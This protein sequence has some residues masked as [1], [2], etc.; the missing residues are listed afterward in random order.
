MANESEIDDAAAVM[1]PINRAWLG[2]NVGDLAPMESIRGL[3][4]SFP[5]LAEEFRG[6]NGFLL[7][8][9]ILPKRNYSRIQQA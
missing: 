5:V 1:R 8:S 9:A 4:W 7:H 6:E 3:G 2:G